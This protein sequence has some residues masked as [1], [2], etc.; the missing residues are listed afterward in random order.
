MAEN[1]IRQF[2]YPRIDEFADR[3]RP[4]PVHNEINAWQHMLNMI[5]QEALKSGLIDE[6]LDVLSSPLQ[7]QDTHQERKT[8]GKSAS[9]SYPEGAV[10]A[11]GKA[12]KLFPI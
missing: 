11:F 7:V 5:Y 10:T 1:G 9:S 4:E 6:F 3:Q 2:V 12:V 8:T